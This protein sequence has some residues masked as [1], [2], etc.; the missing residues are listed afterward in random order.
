M[1]F[2]IFNAPFVTC[3]IAHKGQLAV[4]IL[5][6][7]L[8]EIGISIWNPIDTIPIL[9]PQ[10]F[11]STLREDDHYLFECV[12]FLRFIEKRGSLPD[13]IFGNV[14]HTKCFPHKL[15]DR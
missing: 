2:A 3:H 5:L 15:S 10:F 4:G 13:T 9:N 7:L 6:F 14:I 8:R 11:L 1:H 12:R